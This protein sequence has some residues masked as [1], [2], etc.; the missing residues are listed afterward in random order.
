MEAFAAVLRTVDECNAL[1]LKMTASIADSSNMVK[2]LVIRA[3]DA[4]ILGDM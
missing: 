4:R 2:A 1:R 3:E